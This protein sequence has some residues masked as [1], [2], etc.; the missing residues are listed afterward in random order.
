MGA[1][2][3]GHLSLIRESRRRDEVVIV[4]LFVNPLQFGPSEDYREYPRDLESDATMA[5]A[6][7]ADY[8]FVPAPEAIYP[9]GFRTYVRVEGL[10]D[11]LCGASR[12]GH[13][14]GVATVVAK[15]FNLILPHRAYFGQKDAQQAIIIGKMIADLN[16]DIELVILPTVREEDGLAMS[17]RNAYLSEQERQEATV[18]YRSLRWAEEEIRKGERNADCLREEMRRMISSM[19][20]AKIDYLSLVDTGSLEEVGRLEGKVL[21]A[22]AVWFGKARLIDNSIVSI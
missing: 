12:P 9:P 5:S 7:G 22:L 17:S 15:L 16:W 20:T 18:L 13:F 21:I 8:L 3:E 10:S 1:F 14:R 19:P 4:S 11:K 2:H 6:L